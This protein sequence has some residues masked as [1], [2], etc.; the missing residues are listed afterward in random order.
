MRL[1]GIHHVTAIT[2][3][4]QRSVDFYVGTLGLRF[5][6]R[7]VN[8][9]QPDVY[10]L[11]YGDERGTPG[12]IMTFFEFPGAARGSHG[13]GMIHTVI[14]RVAGPEALDFWELRIA[15]TGMEPHRTEG[16][17]RFTDPEGLG[18][19]LLS[20]AIDEPPL[21]AAAADIPAEHAL[22]GFHGVRAYDAEPV[23]SRPLLETLGFDS[24]EGS[25][26]DY[27]VAGIGR[28]ATYGYDEPPDWPGAQ[29]AGTVHHVAWACQDSDHERWRQLV[30]DAGAHVTPIIDRTYFRSIYFREPSGVL[31]E[32]ATL[33]PGFA[34]DEPA[35]RLGESLVLPPRHEHLRAALEQRLTPVTDPRRGAR[36][37]GSKRPS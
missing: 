15:R 19:E 37:Y 18:I 13:A 26:Y 25:D 17:L 12:S 21:V 16:S 20:V 34:V 23:A 10:H 9:D 36:L 31:F 4:A 5:V 32:I 6:K 1:E 24:P 27:I 28:R 14:W 2:A 7:T 22:Q 30:R 35:D 8:Y 29:G 33:S 3:E 11:Y